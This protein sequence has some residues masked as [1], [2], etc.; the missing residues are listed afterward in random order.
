VGDLKKMDTSQFDA[1]ISTVDIDITT[2]GLQD[3]KYYDA[4]VQ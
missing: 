4:S 1:I 2:P 3:L